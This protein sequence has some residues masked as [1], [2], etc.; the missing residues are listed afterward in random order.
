M[1]LSGRITQLFDE[2]ISTSFFAKEVLIEPLGSAAR[3]IVHSLLDGGKVLVCG[4]GNSA[5]HAQHFSTQMLIHF[6]R[7][8]PGLPAIALTAGSPTLVTTDDGVD[9][10]EI[11]AKQVGALGHPGDLLLVISVDGL[12]QSIWRAVEVAHQR[13]IQVIALTGFDGGELSELLNDKDIELRVPS[14]STTR[15]HEAHLL[16][17]HCL[18][19][20]ID[21]QL[22]G[23]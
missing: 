14:D 16:V 7:E 8:R 15:I 5:P 6:E 3:L 21:A 23:T 4:N 9:F 12:S 17:L 11:Y 18:C 19:D 13:Q 2:N 1:D 20:L 22:L 10:K